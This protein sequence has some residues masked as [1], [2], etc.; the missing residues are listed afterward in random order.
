[1]WE[2]ADAAAVLPALP[3]MVLSFVFHNVVP[4]VCYQLGC[5]L[6]KIRVA[7]LA[8]S[9]LPLVLFLLWTAVILG[10]V[11]PGRAR[12]GPRSSSNFFEFQ[13]ASSMVAIAFIV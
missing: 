5:D 1:M 8:G 7:I 4:T 9:A 13:S 11:R 12:C 3:L 6:R 2:H 10:T